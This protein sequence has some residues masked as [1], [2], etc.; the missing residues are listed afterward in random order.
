M[1]SFYV[2]LQ[3][4]KTNNMQESIRALD[5]AVKRRTEML[6]DSDSL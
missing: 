1:T 3:F 2:V 6:N 4:A 5:E